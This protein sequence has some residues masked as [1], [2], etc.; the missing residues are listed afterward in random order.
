V[1]VE[2]AQN[3]VDAADPDPVRLLIRLS[4]A[5]LEVANTGRPLTAEG[6]AA[7]ASLR[8][9]AKR[10]QAGAVGRFGVGFAAVLAV[11]DRITVGSRDSACVGFDRD[12]TRQAVAREGSAA[13]RSELE[14]RRGH[15][16]VLRL[17]FPVPPV[18]VPDGYDTLV[19]AHL[20]D[21]AAHELAAAL[22]ADLDPT[23]P[24]VLAGLGEITLQSPAGARVLHCRWDRGRAELDGVEWLLAEDTVQVA[25][26]LFAERPTEERHRAEAVGHRVVVRA[27]ARRDAGPL[28]AGAPA[29]L[30]APQPT[31]DPLTLPVVLSV[32]VPLDDSRRRAQSGA[33]TETLLAA[34]GP[35]L[36]D[37]AA[38]IDDP[39]PLV[40]TGL[41]TGEVDASVRRSA[42]RA[43]AD[44]PVLP[45]GRRGREVAVAD[46]GPATGP[47]C[48]LLSG[49]LDELLPA[50]WS[51]PG[52]AAALAVL[53]VRRWD[54]AGLVDALAGL[55][56]PAAFWHDL[57]AA[58]ADAP[59][60]DALGALPVPLVDG[61]RVTGARGTLLAGADLDAAVR[62]T[63]ELAH[64]LADAGAPSAD[65]LRLRVVD[66]AAAH[67]LLLRLGARHADAQLLLDA[68]R[69]A[70]EDSGDLP[71]VLQR[72]LAALVLDLVEQIAPE[73]GSR[74]WLAELVLPAAGGGAPAADL[75]HPDA[76]LR[77]FL[78][79][80]AGLR[81]LDP[82]LAAS[83]APWVWAA[84]GVVHGF[85]VE[86]TE[87][88]VL[89]PSGEAGLPDE[90]G[91]HRYL[92][93]AEPRVAVLDALVAVRDLDLIADWVGALPVLAADPA[94]RA[95]VL[96]PA[97]LGG[98]QVP[99]YTRWWLSTRPVFGGRSA[100][101]L[102][103]P[104]ADPLL[105]GL[106]DPAP[107]LAD[108]ALLAALGARCSLA[109]VLVDPAA[110]ADLADRLGDAARDVSRSQARALY[111][112]LAAHLGDL[113]DPPAPPLSVRAVHGGSLV[114]VPAG[115]AVLIDAPDLVPLVERPVVPAPASC[116][117][118]LHRVLGVPLAGSLGSFPVSGKGEERA[119]PIDGPWPGTYRHVADLR[120]GGTPVS[121]RVTD[122]VVYARDAGG[123]A[124][125]L[126]WAA[127][128]WELRHALAE[129]L[130][131]PA[132]VA[133]LDA[134]D[135]L[136]DPPSGP[137]G[138][139]RPG[140]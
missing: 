77:P 37:L 91:Y 101:E 116:A 126:A 78:D 17:P 124:R 52:R 61:R 26:A 135:D 45:G 80:D 84:V 114:V 107:D 39:L 65:D 103:L 133:L 94:A 100:G 73:A 29:V 40:P 8:A 72:R 2:L 139:D 27:L 63:G 13:L 88:V 15:V 4:P 74:P 138:Q 36:A 59:D 56:R 47:T 121:W 46:L 54:T 34:A 85:V 14:H 38:R 130:T 137:D 134:E 71:G 68:L 12:R 67:S 118:A 1:L 115:A 53:G 102:A 128:R 42:T 92:L 79:P 11:A 24:L 120:V 112:A 18:D 32:P 51:A 25:P 89:D 9:S 140:G 122:G 21:V 6:V 70:V 104:G 20:R 43:L 49:V 33:L 113:P 106:Y 81:V 69:G 87:G 75:V 35:L 55:D 119:V 57:Y 16:P 76:T 58:L 3:A 60:L 23:L 97:S 90:A 64:E 83:R 82:E 10:G 129:R 98:E 109:D 30:R 44:A 111:A 117:P 66:P 105:A 96:E 99:S 19:L 108:P 127:G 93:D 123:L 28:P 48:E 31:D 132:E 125:G 22:L 86:R 5:T 62:E 7:L 41:A 50:A 95:A 136:D 110:A 131:R